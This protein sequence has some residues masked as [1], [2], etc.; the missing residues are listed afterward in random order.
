MIITYRLTLK[1]ML[2]E[3]RTKFQKFKKL[4]KLQSYRYINH[5]EEQ[6]PSL[7]NTKYQNTNSKGA[8]SN[9]LQ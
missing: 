2:I 6:N 3:F 8:K 1:I 4:R 5:M 9:S 7:L